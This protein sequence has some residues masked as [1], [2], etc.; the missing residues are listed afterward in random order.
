MIIHFEIPA[1]NLDRAK[2]FYSELFSWK[3]KELPGRKGYL[4]IRAEGDG[5]I[6]G[7]LMKRMRP[8]QTIINYIDVPSL[9]QCI[10][11]VE[12]LGGK[13]LVNKKAVPG[14]GYF[15]VCLDT[16]NNTFGIWEANHN[17]Q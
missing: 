7:S 16:E 9:D 6:S 1:E 3:I 10:A 2:K 15:A 14:T 17:A 12:R 4:E 8:Q 11:K 13:I 5:T